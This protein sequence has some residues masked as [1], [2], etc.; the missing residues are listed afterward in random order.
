[1]P[2]SC[3][4]KI[5]Q[6]YFLNAITFC[7]TEATFDFNI[8]PNTCIVINLLHCCQSSFS[9]KVKQLYNH[10]LYRIDDV[11]LY[12]SVNDK[13]YLKFQ[14]FQQK[15]KRNPFQF[16]EYSLKLMYYH[17]QFLNG[18]KHICHGYKCHGHNSKPTVYRTNGYHLEVNYPR[19]VIYP[20][21]LRTEAIAYPSEFKW[22]TIMSYRLKSMVYF[23]LKYSSYS[24][25]SSTIYH[26]NCARPSNETCHW[27]GF[28]INLTK[29]VCLDEQMKG[30]ENKIWKS[31]VLRNNI[32][33][34]ILQ[35]PINK[36]KHSKFWKLEV[37][38]NNV[39]QRNHSNDFGDLIF[40]SDPIK[41]C[42][43]TKIEMYKKFF[44]E[45]YQM[46]PCATLETTVNVNAKLLTERKAF[47][48]G[49]QTFENA[50]ILYY[51]DASINLISN[52]TKL[53]YNWISYENVKYNN[54]KFKNR[55]KLLNFAKW[56]YSW[57]MAKAKC[58]EY[59]MTLLHLQNERRT[60]ELVSYI[61][62][63]Y[64]L[65][66]HVM[67]IGLIRKVS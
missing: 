45:F 64:A 1:M 7:F 66:S 39:S 41:L 48:V 18:P 15:Q 44:H 61:F 57:I 12:P 52:E 58:Q 5:Q 33:K 29:K 22:N 50:E 23:S 17:G 49:L 24:W 43:Q 9:D 32:T 8:L 6:Y 20:V 53:F 67:F 59:G 21:H 26:I 30:S 56:K 62:D 37:L 54:Y 55:Y 14:Q 27:T 10:K 13:I 65:P 42:N 40:S 4:L 63:A 16:H 28:G 51:P 35:P 36:N 38:F 46:P 60:R 3:L 19:Y 11:Y 2:D 25:F 47:E 31:V 34:Y